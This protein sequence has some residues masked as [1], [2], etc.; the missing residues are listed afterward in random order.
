MRQTPTLIAACAALLASPVWATDAAKSA[1]EVWQETP[2][3]VI[4]GDT[5]V[6]EEFQWVARPVVIFANSAQDPAFGEQIDL[7]LS[8]VERLIER[9]VVIIADTDP[10]PPSALRTKLRPRGFMLVLIGK[11]GEVELRKPFPW[12]VRELS[13]VIDK[14][15]MRQREIRSGG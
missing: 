12:D 1:L 13:R 2:G 15:P 3:A 9:D 10:S 7:L 11:D 5:V 14:M 8:E 6:L 4:A